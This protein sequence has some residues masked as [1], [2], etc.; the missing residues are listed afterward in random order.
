MKY[1]LFFLLLPGSLYAQDCKLHNDKD[2]YTRE[3]RL[4]TGFIRVGGATL[5]IDATKTEVDLLIT[6][7]GAD[8]C[9]D[10]ST[11]A[12]V[13]FENGKQKYTLRNTGT[14]NCN[15]DFH[16]SARNSKTVT[17]SFL[18]RLSRQKISS[19]KVTGRDK[20]ETEITLTLAQQQQFFDLANCMAEEAKGLVP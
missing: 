16:V 20:K 5:S 6:V 18:Q 2:P 15:G 17:P 1:I 13:F 19:I 11:T 10:N 9:Y 14:M 12:V 4:S 8:K 7:S 3:T